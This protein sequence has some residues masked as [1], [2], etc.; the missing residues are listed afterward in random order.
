VVTNAPAPENGHSEGKSPESTCPVYT[1]KLAKLG[2]NLY[3]QQWGRL[4]ATYQRAN[5]YEVDGILQKLALPQET[6]PEAVIDAL[7]K[8]LDA[9]A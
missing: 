3:P 5:V 6:K 7:N 4:C 1:G 8:Y 9:K 2:K